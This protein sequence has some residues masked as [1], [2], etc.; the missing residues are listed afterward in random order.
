VSA[1]ADVHGQILCPRDSALWRDPSW[2]AKTDI[3]LLRAAVA[4]AAEGPLV[5]VG[6]GGSLT[7][8]SALAFL[9]Q[10]FVSQIAAVATPLEAAA[11]PLQKTISTWLLS[12]GGNNVDILASF[13]ALVRREARQLAVLCG[14]ADSPLSL[15]AQ[16]HGFVDLLVHE[17][18]AGR[19][20]FLATNSLLGFVGLLTRAYCETF[21]GGVWQEVLEHVE[22][23]ID[24][25]GL[26]QMT[27]KAETAFLWERRTT[28]VL[29][30]PA[31]R[32][33]AIDLE[34]K[35]TEAALGNLQVADW[36]NFAHG[37]HHW[38]AKHGD[39]SSILALI[40]SESEAVAERTL[41]L[42]P[43]QV[44]V[45][46]LRFDGSRT[47]AL[48]GSLV[49]ALCVTWWAGMARGIDPGRPGQGKVGWDVERPTSRREQ[50]HCPI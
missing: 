24:P 25:I 1:E 37:R 17:P 49:A 12:A 11:D 5:A 41:A 40:S 29:H 45:A 34:S 50:S 22:P 48:L 43:P 30:G 2:V 9:H 7:A 32:V 13:R 44:P 42:I 16:A 19:D 15:L 39:D 33:G 31:T 47:A 36:R 26:Q 6:S 20:G 23:L 35:F 38:L 14:R 28:V 27:W 46:R 8:A 3:A 18:P 4:E 21:S 10:Q